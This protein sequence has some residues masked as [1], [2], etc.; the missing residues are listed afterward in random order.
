MEKK[1]FFQEFEGVSH[2][3]FW[4][5]SRVS[6]FSAVWAK[7]QGR[8]WLVSNK[9]G[10]GL[11][12]KGQDS[13]ETQEDS[14]IIIFPETA[15]AW[16]DRGYTVQNEKKKVFGLPKILSAGNRFR[17]VVNWKHVLILIK[18]REGR[19]SPDSRAKSHL[20]S[21]VNSR[22]KSWS[23]PFRHLPSWLLRTSNSCVPP[24]PPHPHFSG[25]IVSGGYPSPTLPLHIGWEV[26]NKL[27]LWFTG[28]LL[29]RSHQET[30]LK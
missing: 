14:K 7:A 29:E 2:R 15:P 5:S 26:A 28:L 6:C 9:V 1:I 18:Q 10:Y 20:E 8:E 11:L 22:M 23:R 27:S 24:I 21:F 13:Q 19:Q 16:T 3:W 4:S 12:S 30:I 25:R 17:K